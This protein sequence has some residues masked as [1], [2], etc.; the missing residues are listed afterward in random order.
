MIF[1]DVEVEDKLGGEDAFMQF[2]GRNWPNN[3]LVP[4]K[5][6]VSSPPQPGL[7]NPGSATVICA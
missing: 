5:L 2:S 6:R 7:R 1:V 4:P 3:R